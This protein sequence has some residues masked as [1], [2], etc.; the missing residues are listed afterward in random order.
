MDAQRTPED[1]VPKFTHKGWFMLCPIKVA[2]P[3]SHAPCVAARW[4]VLEPWF[5][6]NEAAQSLMIWVLTMIDPDYEPM[7]MFKI[8]GELK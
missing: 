1:Q 2:Q 3:E 7:W 6:V 5:T 8:T 4:L